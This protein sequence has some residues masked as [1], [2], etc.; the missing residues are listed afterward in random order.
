MP[1]IDFIQ[2]NFL[3]FKVKGTSSVLMSPSMTLEQVSEHHAELCETAFPKITCF[4]F[5]CC[6][7]LFFV[8]FFSVKKYIYFFFIELFCMRDKWHQEWLIAL[9]T[10]QGDITTLKI[11]TENYQQRILQSGVCVM[12]FS[13]HLSDS[14]PHIK[15]ASFYIWASR[16]TVFSWV[17]AFPNSEDHPLTSHFDWKCNQI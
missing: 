9:S 4:F 17:G 1:S 5:C 2:I 11:K 12:A 14:L 7:F 15:L 3:Q 6:S 13:G 16:I 10:P 8:F